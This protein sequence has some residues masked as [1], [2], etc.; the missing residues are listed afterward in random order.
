MNKK[1]KLDV[2]ILRAKIKV[3]ESLKQHQQSWYGEEVEI[4]EEEEDNG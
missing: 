1:Q 4:V 2:M 3:E